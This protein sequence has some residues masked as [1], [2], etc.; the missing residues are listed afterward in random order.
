MNMRNL[1]HPSS[2]AGALA[3]GAIASSK[4]PVKAQPNHQCQFETT[5]SKWIEL[6][7]DIKRKV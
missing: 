6:S 3:T 5:F 7:D 4:I 2:G 1:H